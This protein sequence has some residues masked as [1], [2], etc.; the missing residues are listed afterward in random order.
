MS[1]SLKTI[2]ITGFFK[3]F[4][5]AIRT[6][7]LWDA[8]L[9]VFFCVQA[10]L[11]FRLFYGTMCSVFFSAERNCDMTRHE[12]EAYI[13]SAYGITPD[14]PFT[15]DFVT[16]VFRHPSNRKWFAVAMRISRSK[17]GIPED[18][19]IDV[20]NVKCDPEILHS[21]HGQ[22]GIYPAYHMNRNHWLTV[23]LD[24]CVTEDTM[25]FLLGISYDLTKSK[26]NNKSR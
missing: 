2:D 18:G 7:R 21:F 3:K 10:D 20:V 1:E 24:G 11:T 25:G 13:E 22:P 14:Y 19:F 9:R 5:I 26:K 6:K 23:I 8:N 4:C 17:L 15:G 16:A 12:L